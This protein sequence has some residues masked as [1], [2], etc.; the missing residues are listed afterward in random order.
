MA[1]SKGR[2]RPNT[3]QIVHQ[4]AINRPLSRASTASA[5]SFGQHDGQ[6]PHLAQPQANHP[7]TPQQVIQHIGYASAQPHVNGTHCSNPQQE[8]LLHAVHHMQQQENVMD[9]AHQQQLIAFSNDGGPLQ[10]LDQNIQATSQSYQ[11]T[12]SNSAM[13]VSMDGDDL[14]KKK[15][16]KGGSAGGARDD[17]ELRELINQNTNRGLAEVARD[18]LVLDRSSK[19]EKMKQLFAMLWL[20]KA[21]TTVKDA[22]VPRNRVYSK[23]AEICGDQRV[24]TLN[25]ASFGKLVRVIF[26]GINT[27]RLGVRGE[28]KY[29]Y[30]DLALHEE[31]EGGSRPVTSDPS[32]AMS[33]RHSRRQESIAPIVH[34]SANPPPAA[35]TASFP[36]PDL[37]TLPMN[38]SQGRVFAEPYSQAYH[39]SNSRTAPDYV[40]NL[41][42]PSEDLLANTGDLSINLPDVHPY[43]PA[44]YDEDAA[45]ALVALYR[46]HCTSLVDAVRF[47]KE[48]QFFK[49]FTS[50]HGTLTIPVQKLFAMRELANWIKECDW[51][52]YQIMIRNVSQLTLQVAPPT[53]LKFLD[54][55]G[56]MLH[57]H[58]STTFSTL[59]LHVLEAKLEPATIFAHL[60]RQMLRVNSTAHAAAVALTVD[61]QREAM[62]NDWLAYVKIKR[63]IENV[64]PQSCA[65][66]TVFHILAIEVRDLLIPPW[67]G[68]RAMPEETVIDRISSFLI[69]LP[70]RFPNATTRALLLC[71]DALGSAALREITV[72]NGVSFQGWWLTKVFIDEYAHWLASLGGFLAHTPAIFGP[73]DGSPDL[74]ET[75][76]IDLD[77]VNGGSGG[78][79]NGNN[80]SRFSSMGADNVIDR[81]GRNF[82][83]PT[84]HPNNSGHDTFHQEPTMSFDLNL[85]FNTSQH[86]QSQVELGHDDSGF[87]DNDGLDEKLHMQAFRSLAAAPAMVTHGM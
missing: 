35:D 23:Y 52:M 21:C 31:L 79:S 34:A 18:I 47:C 46:S 80:D 24:T 16:K 69:K 26:P 59:P 27:R 17:R 60:L 72:E 50:F 25:P 1:A 28:S 4:T 38:P 44:K 20:R 48:K 12:Q 84:Q 56:K 37:S 7:G 67:S 55:I 86:D 57:G 6:H 30:V 8:Q 22:S 63:V 36:S 58:I 66:E 51:M 40:Y 43:L 33:R 9:P 65:L 70:S 49:L 77:M 13:S 3:P 75:T 82:S 61:N 62:W 42:F 81:P 83:Q 2:S 41:Q 14:V 54:N 32:G 29:H 39:S 78:S 5:H 74:E 10:V 15:T 71:I 76:N 68:Q 11:M 73:S 53:V 45:N 87:I 19:A 64:L 85:D